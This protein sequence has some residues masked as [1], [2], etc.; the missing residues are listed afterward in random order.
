MRY[1]KELS[2]EHMSNYKISYTSSYW[3]H[4]SRKGKP[5][6]QLILVSI[7]KPARSGSIDKIEKSKSETSTMRETSMER[8]FASFA[9]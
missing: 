2:V 5:S 7:K 9:K 6:Y 4:N 3:A 8:S 1:M